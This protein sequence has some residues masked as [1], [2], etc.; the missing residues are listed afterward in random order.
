MAK[1]EPFQ[2]FL[3]A[4]DAEMAENEPFQAFTI[5]KRR[6]LKTVTVYRSAKAARLALVGDNWNVRYIVEDN[7]VVP[8]RVCGKSPPGRPMR[9]HADGE[10][11]PVYGHVFT[12]EA[13]AVRSYRRDLENHVQRCREE[14]DQI[15]LMRQRCR[16]ELDQ[17]LLMRQRFERAIKT[18][19]ERSRGKL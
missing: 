17:I 14:L 12:T 10:T 11:V 6:R 16:E 3:E 9:I 15:L 8:I 19:S 1:N 18:R 13:E 7:A 2:A 4:L 5:D